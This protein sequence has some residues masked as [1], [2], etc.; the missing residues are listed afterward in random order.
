MPVDRSVKQLGDGVTVINADMPVAAALKLLAMEGISAAPVVDGYNDK[1]Q[2]FITTGDLVSLATT[3]FFSEDATDWG[4]FLDAKDEFKS[5]TVAEALKVTSRFDCYNV[6]YMNQSTYSACELLT[7]PRRYRL[8]LINSQNRICGILTQSMLISMIVQ[9]KHLIDDDLLEMKLRDLETPLFRTVHV[10]NENEMTINALK[11]LVRFK[12]PGLAVVNDAGYLTGAFSENDIRG[13]GMNGN[14]FLRL[15]KPLK[16]FK[17]LERADFPSLAP[18]SHFS[19]NQK[20]LPLQAVTVTPDDTLGQVLDQ[21][22]DGCLHRVFVVTTL[23]K[24]ANRP[25]VINVISLTDVLQLVLD[26]A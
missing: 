17:A 19:Y 12:V 2:G 24:A 20:T 5:T 9:N 21:L 10:V 15:F 11:K 7:Q 4:A 18:P 16:E 23:S 22:E 3:L 6:S 8:A 13:V 25:V 14:H 26:R 1:F